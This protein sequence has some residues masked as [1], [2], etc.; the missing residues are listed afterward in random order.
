MW[1]DPFALMWN[2]VRGRD[3]PQVTA[4][5]PA[6]LVQ[7]ALRAPGRDVMSEA[8]ALEAA[9]MARGLHAVDDEFFRLRDAEWEE[10]GGSAAHV[11]YTGIHCYLTAFQRKTPGAVR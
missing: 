7:R 8:G 2:A 3:R 9:L 4:S 5:T 6:R 10:I 1:W 11:S